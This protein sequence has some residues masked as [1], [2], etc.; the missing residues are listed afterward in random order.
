MSRQDTVASMCACLSRAV[1]FPAHANGR[2]P[3]ATIY[4]SVSGGPLPTGAAL[5]ARH[6][7]WV[8]NHPSYFADALASALADGYDAVVDIG[9]QPAKTFAQALSEVRKFSRPR[10]RIRR[11]LRRAR[12]RSQATAETLDF[13]HPAVVQDLF[14]HYER[15]RR[16][17][18]VLYLA[19][20]GYWFVLGYDDAVAV[21][22]QP[23]VFSAKPMGAIVDP[24]LFGVD[25]E[26]HSAARRKLMAQISSRLTHAADGIEERA[27]RL[28]L[29]LAQRPEFDFVSEFASPLAD[30]VGG[31]FLGLEDQ[32]TAEVRT[33][34]GDWR[35][36]APA[37][38]T[39][40]VALA[41]GLDRA[42]LYRDFLNEPG[43]DEATA[44]H[45]V[46][47]MWA[48]STHTVRLALSSAALILLENDA[49]RRELQA[50][51][52]RVDAFVAEA[53]RLRPPE[54]TL[55]RAAVADVTLGGREIPAG[56]IVRICIGAAGR[57]PEHF[58]DPDRPV[59]DRP[60]SHL[61][62]GGGEHRCAGARLARAEL[63]GELR[64]LLRVMPDFHAVQPLSTVRYVRWDGRHG[65]E[66]LVVAGGREPA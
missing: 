10:S 21:L 12:G 58:P 36:D 41:A 22:T 61:A 7:Q 30:M 1:E 40:E 11:R 45:L 17:G 16:S 23:E 47:L 44:L 29:D 8:M 37:V 38:T 59:L 15:L 49:L 27:E 54:H 50:D 34:M 43:I 57:D 4:T 42:P 65:V 3:A 18:S 46:A 5:D 66:R 14:G 60:V 62:F 33:A 20:Q 9:G 32:T 63:G 26:A 48:S 28:L 13:A 64:A 19:E 56:A 35:G 2:P 52:A 24:I 31:R 55:M 53:L 6:W 51:P 25:G 39:P